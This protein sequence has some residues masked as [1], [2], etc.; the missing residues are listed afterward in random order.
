MQRAARSSNE[1]SARR[2]LE[3]VA[4]RAMD[5]AGASVGLVA[6]GPVMGA[7]ALAVRATMGSP[8]LFRQVRPGLHGEPFTILKL[9]TMIEASTD[10]PDAVR[11]TRLGKLLRSTSVD[12]LPQFWNV[13]RGDMSL[14]GPRALLMEYLPLYS[15]R[16]ARRHE[17]KPGLT[18]W[19]AVHGRNTVSWED[20]FEMDVWYVENQ[21]L[22]LDLKILAMTVAKV[23]AR[24]GVTQEGRATRDP[25]T[26]L[27]PEPG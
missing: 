23:L 2:D 27:A 5:I 19:V 17:V 22:W 9:R 4:K 25:F 8:V 21:S 26:G 3:R 18:S 7:A 15:P 16:H 24:D 13:L 20:Q 1:H 10:Q 6:F 12:E 11:L 14:V